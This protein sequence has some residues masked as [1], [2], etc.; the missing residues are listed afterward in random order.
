MDFHEILE[1]DVKVERLHSGSSQDLNPHSV[2]IN[3]Q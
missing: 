1:R 3:I 2:Y